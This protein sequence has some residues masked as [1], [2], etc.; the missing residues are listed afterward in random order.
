[1]PLFQ[2][3]NGKG[4]PLKVTID[5][6]T[7][8]V[9]RMALIWDTGSTCEPTPV[10]ACAELLPMSPLAPLRGQTPRVHH[11]LAGLELKLDLLR[12]RSPALVEV[13]ALAARTWRKAALAHLGTSEAADGS[14][15][16][17]N[18]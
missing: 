12:E 10:D 16:N 14:K 15:R 9:T 2:T 1:M 5:H 18:N 3:L 8:W 11:H 17:T 6:A 4:L 7:Y 13:S